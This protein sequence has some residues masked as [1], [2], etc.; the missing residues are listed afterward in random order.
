MSDPQTWAALKTTLANWLNRDDLSTTE[1][2]EAISMAERRLNRVLRVPEM[3]D[4]VSTSSASA[5]FTLP[6]DFLEMRSI[7]VDATSKVFLQHVSMAELRSMYPTTASGTPAHFAMQSGNEITV[8]PTPSAST[9]YI[10]NYYQ[11]IPALGSSQA[12]NWLLLAHSDIYIS[13]ALV[14]LYTLLRD[15]EGIAFHEGRLQQRI[16]E[17][18]KQG[19]GKAHGASPLIARHGRHTVRNISA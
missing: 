18:R 19:A 1:I 16:D 7:Y 14:E 12:A 6:S 2:P 17:L 4:A 11:K 9:T 10:V 13:A 3:E 15:P 8:G 5:T